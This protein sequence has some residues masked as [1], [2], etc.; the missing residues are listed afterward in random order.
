MDSVKLIAD[1]LV[2]RETLTKE[3]IDYLLEH[4]K[5]PDED[6][7]VMDFD[8]LK[9]AAKEKGIKG[10]TKMSQEE[11]LEALKSLNKENE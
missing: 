8:S 9:S 3:Q 5:L 10:Y 1:T 6:Y 11:L 4:K 7:D 2:D